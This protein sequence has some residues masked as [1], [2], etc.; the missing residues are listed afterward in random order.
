MHGEAA[1]FVDVVAV[2]RS[3][4]IVSVAGVADG[5]DERAAGPEDATD[6]ADHRVDLLG[7]QGHAQQHV[8]EDGVRAAA[9]QGQRFPYVVNHC[10][11]T[12]A[13]AKVFG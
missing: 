6:L 9:R 5:V 12:V 8:G 7:G 13:D 1:M 3:L 10:R 4:T 2:G 11:D